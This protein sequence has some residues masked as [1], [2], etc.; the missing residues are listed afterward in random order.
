MAALAPG[1]ASFCSF[2]QGFE[3]EGF[4]HFS[5]PESVFWQVWKEKDI[6]DNMQKNETRI[7]MILIVKVI[8]FL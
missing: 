2:P 5:S 4:Y 1:W 8:K 3:E 7:T 6:F